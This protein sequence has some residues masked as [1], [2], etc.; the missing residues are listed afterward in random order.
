V[1][2]PI[3]EGWSFKGACQTMRFF[4][5]I[6]RRL[7]WSAERHARHVGVR[8]GKNC[9]I[10]TRS[11]GSEPYLIEI[12]DNVQI[13]D[14]VRFYCHGGARTLR[15]KFNEPKFDFFGKVIVKDNAYIGN[16]ALI[17]PGVTIGK[18]CIVGAGAVVTKSVPDGKVVAGNPAKIIGSVDDLYS[19]M[20]KFNV[21]SKGMDPQKKREYLLS[22]PSDK[23]ITK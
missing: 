4:L 8:V 15:I 10:A 16:C 12:G 20:L 23:F 11:F 17:M 6:Y 9:A 2:A 18:D 22:L 1:V 3:R 13:T 7:F 14:G 5:N 19:R 21:N